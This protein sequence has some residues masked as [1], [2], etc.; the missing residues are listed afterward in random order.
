VEAEGGF[1][2]FARSSMPGLLRFAMAVTGQ[3]ATAEDVVQT[4]MV[5]AMGAWSRVADQERWRQQA[6]VRRI[7][8]NTNH[9]AWRRWSART[10]LG[11]MPEGAVASRVDAVDDRLLVRQA[12][13]CLTPRQRAVIVMRYFEDLSEAEIAERLGCAPGTVKSTAARALKALR[14]ALVSE[15]A[16]RGR[17]DTNTD[18]D[19]DT[20]IDIDAVAALPARPDC[21][22]DRVLAVS[23]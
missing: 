18:T 11:V 19:I 1:E 23:A 3:R 17:P 13:E 20:D 10:A 14:D 4:S 7:V 8:L 5:R 16:S 6:Y 15:E 2:E 21:D 9:S 12:L 22:D